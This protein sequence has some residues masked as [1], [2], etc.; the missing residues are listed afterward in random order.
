[1]PAIFIAPALFMGAVALLSQSVPLA[2]QKHTTNHHDDNKRG[3][4]QG[5]TWVGVKAHRDTR[6]DYSAQN[7]NQR[8]EWLS[9]ILVVEM[10]TT[11][12]SDGVN[13]ATATESG[14]QTV[15]VTASECVTYKAACEAV[16][17][18]E[19]SG[20]TW[21]IGCSVG[22]DSAGLTVASPEFAYPTGICARCLCAK[23]NAATNQTSVTQLLGDI[24]CL[25][26]STIT[27]FT[28]AVSGS[29]PE[30]STVPLNNNDNDN[31]HNNNGNSSNSLT[32]PLTLSLALVAV[33]A[34]AAAVY[35][36]MKRKNRWYEREQRIPSPP[37]LNEPSDSTTTLFAGKKAAVPSVATV[38]ATLS[39]KPFLMS[40]WTATTT[41][42]TNESKADD[43]SRLNTKTTT[44]TVEAYP[45]SSLQKRPHLMINS[46]PPGPPPPETITTTNSTTDEPSND[47]TILNQRLQ[48]SPTPLVHV[49]HTPYLPSDSFLTPKTSGVTI[50]AVA[51]NRAWSLE[52]QWQWEQYQAAVQWHQWQLAQ[53]EWQAS[54]REY[55]MSKEEERKNKIAAG[56]GGSGAEDDDRMPEDGRVQQQRKRAFSKGGFLGPNYRPSPLRVVSADVDSTLSSRRAESIISREGSLVSR[57]LSSNGAYGTL[58]V[59]GN[60]ANRQSIDTFTNPL[61]NTGTSFGESFANSISRTTSR[62]SVGSSTKSA[63]TSIIIATSPEWSAPL[64]L[65]QVGSPRSTATSNNRSRSRIS[66]AH[67]STIEVETESMDASGA[68]TSTYVTSST[69]ALGEDVSVITMTSVGDD[70]QPLTTQLLSSMPVIVQDSVTAAVAGTSSSSNATLNLS[71]SSPTTS[72]FGNQGYDGRSSSPDFRVTSSSRKSSGKSYGSLTEPIPPL[73][74]ATNTVIVGVTATGKLFEEPSVIS[75]NTQQE[76][77]MTAAGVAQDLVDEDGQIKYPVR[78]AYVPEKED[79]LRLDVDDEVV[80]WHI[81]E[82]GMCE[83]FCVGKRERGFFPVKVV[84]G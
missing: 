53:K 70:G 84:L 78:V 20:G 74:T 43:G 55:Y 36:Y 62:R 24:P 72:T 57:T 8:D 21:T 81:L 15:L 59:G 9:Q 26:T 40:M 66:S 83:G 49:Q 56:S 7:D 73:P 42:T 35:F 67:K 30:N 27:N 2:I 5:S 54:Q 65:I 82:D 48:A 69:F 37:A 34:A 39:R 1:M 68:L 22:I 76:A 11:L 4:S 23:K 45:S 13:T 41:T 52:E 3:K 38:P 58:G 46:T 31:I 17:M 50:A 80:V 71:A 79:E 16:G 6:A 10:A 60:T 32:L 61:F 75:E 19:C 18:T 47:S 12:T 63:V 33:I 14:V 44:V 77:M 28:V 29:S 64:D 25:A 51:V